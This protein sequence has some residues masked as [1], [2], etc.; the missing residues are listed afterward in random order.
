[1]T[2]GQQ[3]F[4]GVRRPYPDEAVHVHPS[5]KQRK[6]VLLAVDDEGRY[7]LVA[8]HMEEYVLEHSPLGRVKRATLFRAVNVDGVEFLWPVFMPIGKN[9][10]V[11]TAM[12]HW[13]AIGDEPSESLH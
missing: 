7:H 1:M 10:P 8:D 3:K 2:E 11:F 9:H 12:Q 13:I 5:K 6:T 4:D